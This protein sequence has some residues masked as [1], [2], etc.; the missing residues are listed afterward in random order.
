MWIL[1]PDKPPLDEYIRAI[2]AGQKYSPGPGEPIPVPGQPQVGVVD[3]HGRQP[4]AL[5]D[6]DGRFTVRGVGA[7][8]IIRMMVWGPAIDLCTID[9]AT[10]PAPDG[11]SQSDAGNAFH[12]AGPPD[13]S[14]GF[15]G[16]FAA[17]RAGFG[18]WRHEPDL[19][20][21]YARFTHVSHPVRVL[22]GVIRDRDNKRPLTGA[23]IRA[24]T[25]PA[26]TDVE[27]RFE[28]AN[29]PK[30][31]R[32]AIEVTTT[33]GQYLNITLPV[34]DTPGIGPLE[35]DVDLPKGITARGRV[36]DQ[37][38][39]E[40][41]EGSVEYEALFPNPY[42]DRYGLN[43]NSG[44]GLIPRSSGR[45]GKDGRYELQVLPGPGVILFRDKD[46]YTAQWPRH[47]IYASPTIDMKRLNEVLGGAA[48]SGAVNNGATNG[49]VNNEEQLCIAGESGFWILGR[50]GHKALELIRP[51]EGT[52]FITQDLKL[53]RGHDLQG[54][55]LDP[56]GKPAREVWASGLLIEPIR[57][58]H[59]DNGKFTVNCVPPDESRFVLFRGNNLATALEIPKGATGPLTVR[60]GPSATVVGRIVDAT[61]R[62]AYKAKVEIGPRKRAS[63]GV[64]QI[65]V[66]RNGPSDADGQFSISN[67]VPGI[68]FSVVV[69]GKPVKSVKLKPGEKHDAGTIRLT[70]KAD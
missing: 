67:L 23:R 55:L 37:Q 53:V 41:I 28:I 1:P 18:K 24:N 36:I 32:Y 42:L 26:T 35:F 44:I 51:Q 4:N 63:T 52:A 19:S 43:R 8:R 38:T 60:L 5:T 58:W 50:H 57:L 25:Y 62:P 13:K 29:C 45:V 66:P 46:F 40:P 56:D 14:A 11:K 9:V 39:G 21:Y 49:A 54:I 20:H 69:N 70:S 6:R 31:D 15:G 65:I 22:R 59:I 17:A 7:E 34:P 33:S 48:G 12:L 61:G 27:G 10:R 47:E 3:P 2:R 30:R 68:E 16:G 64:F